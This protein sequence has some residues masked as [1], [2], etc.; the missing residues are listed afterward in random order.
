ML[1]YKEFHEIQMNYLKCTK[2]FQQEEK[3]WRAKARE[4]YENTT[5]S[6]VL[7]TDTL[8]LEINENTIQIII[9]DLNGD[10]KFEKNIDTDIFVKQ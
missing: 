2:L 6:S 10:I 1:N 5:H 9:I 7:E 4:I 3:K 8:H